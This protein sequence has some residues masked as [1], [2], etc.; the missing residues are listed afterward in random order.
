LVAQFHF[1]EFVEFFLRRPPVAMK[2]FQVFVQA[3]TS[4]LKEWR[5]RTMI[6][7]R[8]QTQGAGAGAFVGVGGSGAGTGTGAGTTAAA[9]T[10]AAAAVDDDGAKSA[11]SSSSGDAAGAA[12]A[13]IRESR[14]VLVHSIPSKKVF[15]LLRAAHGAKMRMGQELNDVDLTS[16]SRR[17]QIVVGLRRLNQIDP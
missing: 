8:A 10:A 16:L 3:S 15:E 17:L 9:A 14:P 11:A 2:L 7:H 13:S 1:D 6:A 4:K 5:L 12:A